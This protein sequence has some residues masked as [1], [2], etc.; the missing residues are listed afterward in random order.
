VGLG[1]P[2]AAPAGRQEGLTT[3]PASVVTVARKTPPVA[4]GNGE[5]H[6]GN[7]GSGVVVWSDGKTS[8]V[9]TAKHVVPDD[10]LG[11]TVTHA[12]TAYPAKVRLVGNT[13]D[14]AILAVD[15]AL[16]AAEVLDRGPGDGVTLTH[17][18]KT[19]GRAQGKAI[20]W[21]SVGGA[22]YVQA[23]YPSA[24]GDSGAGVFDPAG[25]LA[26]VHTGRQGEVVTRRAVAPSVVKQYVE[27]AL[28]GHARIPGTVAAAAPVQAFGVPGNCPGGVCY[29]AA[30]AGG[31]GAPV[32]YPA[33]GAAPGGTYC[34]TGRCPN[35][36]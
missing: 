19:T 23:D 14:L 5:F 36:R 28:A 27:W 10:G 12:G 34:P 18:G 35:A 6:V 22:E 24:E 26:G 15:A 9:A 7:G 4:L 20:G 13:Q 17:F 29:P 31:F 30:P 1:S 33:F 11:V 21:V 25:R 2:A 8:L 3:A 32:Q 16:P